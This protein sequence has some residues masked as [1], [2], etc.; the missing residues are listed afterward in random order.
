MSPF[1][2]KAVRAVRVDPYLLVRRG[3]RI[4]ARSSSAQLE[5]GT[6]S[7]KKL[8][9]HPLLNPSGTTS[10]H[11]LPPGYS[12]STGERESRPFREEPGTSVPMLSMVLALYFF[13]LS[14]H[15]ALPTCQPPFMVR[16]LQL[17]EVRPYAEEEDFETSLLFVRRA[18]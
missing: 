17:V 14:M 1:F 6:V 4:Y 15:S 2:L 9:L 5:T 13:W 12:T 3:V 8:Y 18:V 10:Y 16:S 11:K 7:Q